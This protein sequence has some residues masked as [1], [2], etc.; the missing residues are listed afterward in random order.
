MDFTHSLSRFEFECLIGPDARAIAACIDRA[1]SAAAVAPGQIDVVLRTGGSSRIPR[2]VR[3]LAERFG[4]ERIQAIDAFTSVGAGLAVA[5]W[6]NAEP[7]AR[8]QRVL[9]A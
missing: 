9:L 1:L 5:A 8:R 4:P 6:E 3:L 2:F 7:A